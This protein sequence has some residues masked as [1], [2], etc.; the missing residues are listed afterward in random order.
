VTLT[1]TPTPTPTPARPHVD[2]GIYVPQVAF[3]YDDVLLRARTLEEL[4]FHSLWL[5]DHLYAP[6]LP[7]TPSLEGW[8]LASFLLALTTRLR[9]G[10]LVLC[11]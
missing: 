8:T 6:M 9:L 11:K 3:S 2:F 5:Y 7:G 1:S 10:H 4:G